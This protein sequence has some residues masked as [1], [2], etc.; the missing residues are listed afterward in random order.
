[1]YEIMDTIN[2]HFVKSVEY[3]KVEITSD[4]TL[5]G[6]F[7]SLY[8]KGMYVI[9]KNSYLNNGVYEIDSVE[10]GVIT[11]KE[12]LQEENTGQPMFIVASIPNKG[13]VDLANKINT[14]KLTNNGG[15]KSKSVQDL[16][17]VYNGDNSWQNVF[18][19][20]LNSY[21]KLFND[22]DLSV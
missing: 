2:N 17:I 6:D 21:R 9:I 11:V 8:L 12:D 18:E 19:K 4:N 7:K 20:R 1:L 10:P 13:F 22:L 15:V 14:F 3:K 5:V 16:Q